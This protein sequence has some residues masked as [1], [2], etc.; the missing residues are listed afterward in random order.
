[1]ST[2]CR[3]R[4]MPALFRESGAVNAIRSYLLTIHHSQKTLRSH[5]S[6]LTIAYLCTA[7]MKLLSPDQ[8][9]Q[10]DN[11]T[12]KHEPI[13]SIDLMERA[14]IACVEWINARGFENRPIKIFCGKGNNGGDGL[15]IARLLLQQGLHPIT[16]I[17]EFGKPGTDDFQKNLQRLHKLSTD[18]HFLQSKEFF[19]VINKNDLVIDA[20]FG[21]GLN[22]PLDALNEELVKHLNQS[23]AT[24]VSID[25]PSGMLVEDACKDHAVVCAAHTL[26]FQRLKRCFLMAENADW[27]GEISI[28]DIGL[29]KTFPETIDTVFSIISQSLVRSLVQ[30]RKPFSHKGNYGHALLLAG[31]KGKVGAAILAAK[32][33]LRSGVGVLTVNVPKAVSSIMYASLPETMVMAREENIPFLNAYKSIGIGPG[34]GVGTNS[35]KIL[36]HILTHYSNPLLIDADALTILSAHKEWLQ[37]IPPGSILSPH[38]KEFDRL[39]GDCANDFERAD[40][41]IAL[42]KQFPFTIIVK[43]HHTLVAAEGKGWY[44]V[45]GNAGL[46]KAGS[47]DTLSGILTALLA[48]QY[49]SLHAAIIGVH[50]HGLAA[51]LALNEQTEESLLATDVIDHIGAA[52]KELRS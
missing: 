30:P 50:L 28:L 10:W 27:F 16:Y 29:H 33:C 21:F 34:F 39:F 26:T 5:D 6:R 51:D 52:F 13:A 1:M 32:A 35:E 25:M 17:L 42:S 46:A 7:L 9:R 11:F 37:N 48:Q 4:L 43:G 18:I 19:P 40:K 44:N 14:A 22:R 20:L 45:S 24:I 3:C 2:E 36:L 8:I 12:I 38:P 41:A 23:G 47:G 15:A 49:T 31:N